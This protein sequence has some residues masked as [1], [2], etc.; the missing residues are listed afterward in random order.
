MGRGSAVHGACVRH[1]RR[2][3]GDEGEEEAMTKAE[4]M[5]LGAATIDA[6]RA[7]GEMAGALDTRLLRARQ[8]YRRAPLALTEARR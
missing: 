1:V 6:L 2:A 7:V 3:R 4:R 8:A 5:I